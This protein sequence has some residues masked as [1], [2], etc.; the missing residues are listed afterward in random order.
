MTCIRPDY[1]EEAR[2]ANLSL[3]SLIEK[4][5]DLKQAQVNLEGLGPACLPIVTPVTSPDP[6]ELPKHDLPCPIYTSDTAAL[7]RTPK[8]NI[9]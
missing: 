2:R 4:A 6:K 3:E 1:S 8:E 5:A 7:Y 9:D